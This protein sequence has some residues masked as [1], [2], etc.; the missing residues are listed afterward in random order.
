[1]TGQVRLQIVGDIVGNLL[2]PFIERSDSGQ[3]RIQ[4][5]RQPVKLVA[6]AGHRQPPGEVASHDASA[7]H[8]DIVDA[9]QGR[10]ANEKPDHEAAKTHHA[11]RKQQSAAHYPPDPLGFAQ[12]ATDQHDDL[13]WEAQN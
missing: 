8:L 11:E 1:Y 13:V 5:L 7:R 12:I 9:L 10:A 6:S 4:S 3:H 2:Q